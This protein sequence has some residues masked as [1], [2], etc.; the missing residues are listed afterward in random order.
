MNPQTVDSS[1]R[2][3]SCKARELEKAEEQYFNA[4]KRTLSDPA[5]SN[6]YK[7]ELRRAFEQTEFKFIDKNKWGYYL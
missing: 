5:V 6:R 1:W 3:L 7:K 2:Q 4:V